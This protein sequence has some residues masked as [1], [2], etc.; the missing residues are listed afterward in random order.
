MSVRDIIKDFG[1][2]SD[3]KTYSFI[4]ELIKELPTSKL[5]DLYNWLDE[6]C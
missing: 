5:V 3:D 1:E 2:W 4:I 6:Y